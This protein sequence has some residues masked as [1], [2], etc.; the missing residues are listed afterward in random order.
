MYIEHVPNR[1]SPPTILLRES[2][3]DGHIVRKRTLAN[4]TQWP[5]QLVEGLQ[6]L[7][8]GGTAMDQL[9][10][11]FE[12]IR[13][14]PHGHV[15]AVLGTLHRLGL[16]RMMAPTPS[17]ER[18]CVVAMVVARL[19]D[20]KSK[21]ATARGLQAATLTREASTFIYAKPPAFLSDPFFTRPVSAKALATLKTAAYQKS[22]ADDP[23]FHEYPAFL[24]TAKKNLKKLSDA[25]IRYGFGTDAGPPGRFPG[26][27]EHWE[28]E[29]MVEAGLT[30]QQVIRAATGSA[31]EY[32]K[33][34]D[35]GTLETGKWAD[36][37]VLNA[38]PL[39]NIRNTRSI[40]AVYIAGNRVGSH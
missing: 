24:E 12:I 30:P 27:F 11:A 22:V 38:D 8:R 13:S 31:A 3:R 40:D 33:A 28:M 37:I 2:Y 20:P 19:L 23:D 29:L 7:L 36:M 21:L 4:L 14:R 9:N 26:F 35:L 15:A 1:N 34:K 16:E 6:T 18:A 39:R 10:A 17:R 32:L 5:S 25:G